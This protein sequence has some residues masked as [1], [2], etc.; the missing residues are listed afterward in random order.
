MRPKWG[1]WK[2]RLSVPG[3]F[4]LDWH[5]SADARETLKAI[6]AAPGKPVLADLLQGEA[7][8]PSAEGRLS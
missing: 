5:L 3:W 7:E 6:V 1:E 4:R 2:P 8:Y